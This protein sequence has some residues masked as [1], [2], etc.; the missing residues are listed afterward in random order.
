[1]GHLH[2]AASE[3]HEAHVWRSAATLPDAIPGRGLKA[4]LLSG[5][6]EGGRT[7]RKPSVGQRRRGGG[8]TP[9]PRGGK[10]EGG[11]PRRK[12]SVG[13]RRRGAHSNASQRPSSGQCRKIGG[14][15]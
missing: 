13:Q 7:R 3:N 14:C 2:N 1:M 10:E 9:F 11:R 15:K 5:I 12:P 6:E 4:F 8:I